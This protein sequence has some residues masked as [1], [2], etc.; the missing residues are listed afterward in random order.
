VV[1]A[2]I[3]KTTRQVVKTAPTGVAARRI[4]GHT[5]HHIFELVHQVYLPDFNP[6]LAQE[7][8]DVLA[9]LDVLIIDEISMVRADLLNTIDRTLQLANCNDLPFGGKQIVLVGDLYQLNPVAKDRVKE[10]LKRYYGGINPY[11]AVSW[12][13][14]RFLFIDLQQTHRQS[15]PVFITLLNW[16]RTG[17]TPEFASREDLVAYANSILNICAEP[18]P[19]AVILCSMNRRAAEINQERDALLEEEDV[20]CFRASYTGVVDFTEMQAPPQLHLRK[21]SRVLLVANKLNI[22]ERSYLYT[23]GDQGWV[24]EIEEKA[25]HVKLDNGNTVL[26]RAHRWVNNMIVYD[27]SKGTL[28]EHQIGEYHQLPLKLGYAISVHK[29]QG[30]SMDRVHL[31]LSRR[32]FAPGMLYVALSRCRTLSGLTISR[33]LHHSELI[34]DPEIEKFYSRQLIEK[35]AG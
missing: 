29:S 18:D 9:A 13:E 14:S 15:D 23:N 21:G 27:E 24:T 12:S 34:Y 5:L 35:S 3:R 16:L 26:V 19:G 30:L 8:L 22:D 28:R 25:V 33:P 1:E 2:F 4:G 6:C 31:D 10:L 32:L 7:S 17:D 11:H 20:V